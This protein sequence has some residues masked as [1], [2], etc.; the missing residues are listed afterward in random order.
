M[1]IK[2]LTGRGAVP[3]KLG[4]LFKGDKKQ[5]RK[6]DRGQEYTTFGKEL[7]YWRFESDRPEVMKAFA[8]AFKDIGGNP[9]EI[10]IYL[11][12]RTAAENFA[13]WKEAYTAGGLSHRCDGE[14]CTVWLEEVRKP[15]EK[16]PVTR[17][18]TEPIP[19]PTIG[20][21]AEKAKKL[22]CKQ[23]GRLQVII[24][25]LKQLGVVTVETHS[26]NDIIFL[27]SYLSFLEGLNPDGI[28]RIPLILARV[29]ESISTPR[30]GKRVRVDK[31][32]VKLWP[33]VEWAE[34]FLAG[35]YRQV[36]GSADAPLQLTAGSASDA[37][38]SDF[39]DW[40]EYGE[41]IDAEP[42]IEAPKIEPPQAKVATP[43]AK[44]P[45]GKKMIALLVPLK[46]PEST[47][48]RMVNTQCQLE[49][50]DLV[51]AVDGITV[52]DQQAIIAEMERE[53]KR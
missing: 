41:V 10:P 6:N 44:S 9:V 34:K 30:D 3:E 32:L 8:E 20:M 27:D 1:A 19:C 37:G 13:A 24:P 12:F 53:M 17:Y 38:E 35:Q 22:G 29:K 11:P 52:E 46:W 40:D 23:V 31:W 49:C 18:S 2:N 48:L 47:L 36:L 7:P 25:A 33:Q 51:E 16:T 26:I 45:L 42:V 21:D 14:T 5:V 4:K 43:K 39:E 28:N 15:G 50:T